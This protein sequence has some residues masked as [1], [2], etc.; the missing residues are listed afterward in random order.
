VYAKR[1]RKGAYFPQCENRWKAICP[2]QQSQSVIGVLSG[3]KDTLTGI[4]D[5]AMVGSLFRKGEF[6]EELNT[7]GNS[8]KFKRK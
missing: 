2:K 5:V 1:S 4:I 6:H 3:Q 8:Y 7:Y